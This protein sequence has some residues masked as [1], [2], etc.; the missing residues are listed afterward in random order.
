[1]GWVELGWGGVGVVGWDGVGRYFYCYETRIGVYVGKMQLLFAVSM[2]V[3]ADHRVSMHAHRM[4]K[5]AGNF[6]WVFSN[7]KSDDQRKFS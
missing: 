7:A 4:S 3:C 5:C 2:Y 6:Q 1:M